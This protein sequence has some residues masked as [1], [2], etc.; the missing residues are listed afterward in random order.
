MRIPNS[1]FYTLANVELNQI[2]EANADLLK[3]ASNGLRVQKPSDDPAAAALSLRLKSQLAD[4]QASSSSLQ[5]GLD[6]LS[7][8][9]LG[10]SDGISILQKA[11]ELSLQAAN[12]HL[13]ATDLKAIGEEADGLVKSM[14]AVGNRQVA[15]RY[16]FAGTASTTKPFTLTGSQVTYNGDA[17]VRETELAPGVTIT[18]TIPGNKAFSDGGDGDALAAL[19]ALRDAAAKGDVDALSGSVQ[20]KLTASHNYLLQQQTRV[21]AWQTGLQQQ[22]D[23][24]STATLNSKQ[25]LSNNEDA[26]MAAVLTA[27][28]ASQQRQQAALAVISKASQS[29]LVNTLA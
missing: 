19:V 27:I 2:N 26:D 18:T 23:S 10:L 28:Q 11:Q 13:S 1:T 17:G 7:T 9:E 14:L 24:L 4:Q 21:G 29:T 25:A 22:L 16:V 8:A 20:T 3:Q 15:G 5:H 12:G 6:N